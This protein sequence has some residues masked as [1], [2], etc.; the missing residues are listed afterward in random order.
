MPYC[1]LYKMDDCVIHII[2]AWH[3][4]LNKIGLLFYFRV[5]VV[6]IVTLVITGRGGTVDEIS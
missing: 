6:T 4:V 3:Y 1:L 5:Y 2:I